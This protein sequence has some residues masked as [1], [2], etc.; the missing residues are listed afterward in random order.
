MEE[1]FTYPSIMYQEKGEDKIYIR[2]PDFPGLCAFGNTRQEAVQQAQEALAMLLIALIDEKRPLPEPEQAG[3][4]TVKEGEQLLYIQ[5][6]LPYF[7]STMKEIYVKKSVTVPT[8]LDELAKSKNLNFSAAL[9]RGLK[10]ELG[11]GSGK[12]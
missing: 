6:W 4:M 8:W 2:F 9:V 10:E 1:N 3:D 11:I 7:R 12:S 5:L